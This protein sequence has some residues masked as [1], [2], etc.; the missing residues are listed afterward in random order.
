M[1]DSVAIHVCKRIDWQVRYAARFAAG[2][3]RHNFK[4]NVT[5]ER[6]TQG[7]IHILLGPWFA[8][9]RWKHGRSILVDRAYWG[10]PDCVSIHWLKDGEKHF[11]WKKDPRPIP[12]LQP[13]REETKSIYLC[14]YRTLPDVKT[15]S[16]R[17]HPSDGGK[18]MLAQALD[19][20]GIA[21]GR[22]T[23]A[24][25]DASV[26]GLEVRTNDKHSPAYPIS[27]K[28]EGRDVWLRG[29][30]WHNWSIEEI[31]RGVYL[32]AIGHRYPF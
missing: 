20:H 3:R 21:Y 8:Y 32:D 7:D 11:T 31:E 29:L 6:A 19:G 9:S 13:W 16:V 27:N 14:D 23:T 18:G 12:E 26:M 17:L 5:S 1:G 22:R 10:D 25:V 2:L 30:A 28:R 15:D 24:L 4:V